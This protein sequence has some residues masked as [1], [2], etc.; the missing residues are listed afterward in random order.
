MRFL[1]EAHS[2]GILAHPHY[3]TTEVLHLSKQDPLAHADPTYARRRSLKIVRRSA[4]CPPA[5]TQLH[6]GVASGDSD[7]VGGYPQCL[8]PRGTGGYSEARPRARVPSDDKRRK[9]AAAYLLASSRFYRELRVGV[10]AAGGPCPA[11]RFFQREKEF[12]HFKS[13]KFCY[14]G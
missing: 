1:R 4:Y 3:I 13:D 6:R 5:A 9:Y 12:F 14:L 8:A 10:G 11:G 7:V 2:T